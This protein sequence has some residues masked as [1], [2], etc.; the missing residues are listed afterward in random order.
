MCDAS[1]VCRDLKHKSVLEKLHI[2]A[3]Q[4][5]GRFGSTAVVK[6]ACPAAVGAEDTEYWEHLN[7]LIGEYFDQLMGRPAAED[8]DDDSTTEESSDGLEEL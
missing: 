3:V 1:C 4:L 5:A 2:R 6:A 7:E 8:E